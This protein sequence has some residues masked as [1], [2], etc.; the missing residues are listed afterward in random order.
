M[1]LIYWW[2]QEY[3][4]TQATRECEVAKD[5]AIDVYQWLREI[6]SWRLINHDDLRLGGTSV[7]TKVVEIDESC[8]STNQ[9]YTNYYYPPTDFNS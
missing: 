5:T 9:R 8:F 2:I 6:G 3:P 7:T 1:L 4:V